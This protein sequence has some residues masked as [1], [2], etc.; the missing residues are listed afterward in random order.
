MK[1]NNLTIKLKII[2]FISVIKNNFMLIGNFHHNIIIVDI[3]ISLDIH[4]QNNFRTSCLYFFENCFS[5]Q[6]G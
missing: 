3:N 1:N 2:Y 5:K 4:R 6:V